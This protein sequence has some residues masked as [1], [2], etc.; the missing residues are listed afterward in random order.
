MGVM[1]LILGPSPFSQFLVFYLSSL[2]PN[3]TQLFKPEVLNLWPMEPSHLVHGAPHGSRNFSVGKQWPLIQPP[4]PFSNPH[5]PIS[6][7]LVGAKLYLLS[8]GVRSH[9]CIR[10]RPCTL[11]SLWGQVGSGHGARLYQAPFLSAG[12]G[13]TPYHSWGWVRAWLY[14]FLPPSQG[15]AMTPSLFTGLCWSLATLPSVHR[16]KL[17]SFPLWGCTGGSLPPIPSS[18]AWCCLLCLPRHCIRNTGWIWTLDGLGWP[19]PIWPFG[20]KAW[21]H[22]FKPFLS[23]SLPLVIGKLLMAPGLLFYPVSWAKVLLWC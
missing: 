11:P 18:T 9:F 7:C 10:A 1:Y 20:Q 19:G 6:E 3:S 15:W 13:Q 8:H 22:C 21:H 12:P 14:P 23:V 17:N 5:I 2:S 4:S 16:A